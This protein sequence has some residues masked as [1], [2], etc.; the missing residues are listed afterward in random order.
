M[1]FYDRQ[2]T[3]ATLQ[4]VKRRIERD[5][6]LVGVVEQLEDFIEVLA[7]LTPSMFRNLPQAYNITG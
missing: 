2:N 7:Y 4:V 5:Y 6:L 1:F 3:E